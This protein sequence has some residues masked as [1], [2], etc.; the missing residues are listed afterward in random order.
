MGSLL[1]RSRRPGQS[2]DQDDEEAASLTRELDMTKELEDLRRMRQNLP[3]EVIYVDD[4]DTFSLILVA[5][6]F[7]YTSLLV[8]SIFLI[9]I[10]TYFLSIYEDGGIFTQERELKPNPFLG[11]PRGASMLVIVSQGLAILIISLVKEA[12]WQGLISFILD[13]QSYISNHETRVLLSKFL[14]IV[15]GCFGIMVIFIHIIRSDDVVYLM[16]DFT[17]MTFISDLDN[18][19]FVIAEMK[20]LGISIERDCKK[21]KKRRNDSIRSRKVFCIN[22]R[23]TILMVIIVT[24]LV[25][26]GVTIV[27]PIMNYKFLCQKIYIQLKDDIIK[28]FSYHSG[29]YILQKRPFGL[30][31]TVT[32]FEDANT[33]TPMILRY[34]EN[35]RAWVFT[36]PTPYEQK[37]ECQQQFFKAISM[38]VLDEETFNVFE[39]PVGSWFYKDN[40]GQTIRSSLFRMCNDENNP[41]IKMPNSSRCDTI[42]FDDNKKPRTHG[43]AFLYRKFSSSFSALTNSTNHKVEVNGRPVY[44]NQTQDLFDIVFYLG[45]RW[46]ITSSKFLYG[47]TDNE[48]NSG[49]KQGL[50]EADSRD[51][52]SNYLETKFHGRWSNY[53][54]DLFSQAVLANTP[55][56]RLTPIELKWYPVFNKK[57]S[58]RTADQ[59]TYVDKEFIC[60][61]CNKF[62]PCYYDNVCIESTSTCDCKNGT[63]GTLCENL[64]LSNGFCNLKFNNLEYDYDGGD[65]CEHTC[66]SSREHEC[67]YDETGDFFL[68]FEVCKN[69]KPWL[70]DWSSWEVTY[71]LSFQREAIKNVGLSSSGQLVGVSFKDSNSVR[72]YDLVASNLIMRGSSIRY[73]TETLSETFGTGIQISTQRKMIRN[74]RSFLPVSVLIRSDHEIYNSEWDDYSILW[75][76]NAIDLN[77]TKTD[78]IRSFQLHTDGNIF[79]VNY[80]KSKSLV[81]TRQSRD[82]TWTY[83]QNPTLL[84]GKSTT[85]DLSQIS[86]CDNDKLVFANKRCF[87]LFSFDI[88]TGFDHIHSACTQGE[89]QTIKVSIKCD[90]F[91]AVTDYRQISS[92]GLIEAFYIK[93]NKFEKINTPLRGI[94]IHETVESIRYSSTSLEIITN[95]KPGERIS[96]FLYGNERWTRFDQRQRM[97]WGIS[98]DGTKS[99]EI[100]KT[101]ESV[102]SIGVSHSVAVYSRES[103]CGKGEH[104]FFTFDVHDGPR[105]FF[106]EIVGY[107]YEST[108]I[109]ETRVGKIYNTNGAAYSEKI[110]V[111]NLRISCFAVIVN[112]TVLKDS[113]NHYGIGMAAGGT[114]KWKTQNNQTYHV[115]NIPVGNDGY[116]E[117]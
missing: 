46:A 85:Q 23:F 70:F 54:I 108:A 61:L 71:P 12:F 5:K 24:L 64:P 32:Y 66:K 1:S 33:A 38:K 35:Q 47:Y 96:L 82:D 111:S 58:N 45:R 98:A 67:G 115:Y 27:A 94:K 44:V 65:C 110:C 15:E 8:C 19:A 75:K 117:K 77:T 92:D 106:W 20:F 34:C 87:G 74:K 26:W 60:S 22:T 76:T 18:I 72:I 100:I 40:D 89:I 114:V 88:I 51:A 103:I 112:S 28:D 78:K 50:S 16:K 59:R 57:S 14:R 79:C 52:L 109:K 43:D 4:Y 95:D 37:Y 2:T 29:H 73:N 3:G 55:K 93:E 97:G 25:I 11:C 81:Y 62:N 41:N 113:S 49:T 48:R 36:L 39:V 9:Q 56:D 6:L 99:V 21:L 86:M 101:R 104:Y 53:S 7:S 10:V 102:D 91:A 17:A 90:A 83:R 63:S 42:Q 30:T 13:F 107:S 31:S 116:C 80:E 69:K 105:N 68:G 84:I